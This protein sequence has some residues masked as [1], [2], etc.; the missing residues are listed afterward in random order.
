M[1]IYVDDMETPYIT[2]ATGRNLSN[3]EQHR[4]LYKLDEL[5]YG[6]HNVKVVITSGIFVMDGVMILAKEAPG[7]KNHV[8]ITESLEVPVALESADLA[9]ILPAT[10]KAEG[11][12]NGVKFTDRELPV[13][14]ND[15]TLKGKTWS[16]VTIDGI[17]IMGDIE[18]PITSRINLVIPPNMVYFVDAGTRETG[19]D[20]YDAIKALNIGLLNEVS[21]KAGDGDNTTASSTWGSAAGPNGLPKASGANRS[22]MFTSLLY[23]NLN[24]SGSDFYYDFTFDEPGIYYLAMGFYMPSGWG[25][26]T[27]RVTALGDA[28]AGP[29]T[30][31]NSLSVTTTPRTMSGMSIEVQQPGSVRLYFERRTGDAAVVSW[32][33]IHGQE[34]VGTPTASVES[35]TY[36]NAITV[37]LTSATEGADIYYTTDGSIPSVSDQVYTKLYTGPIDISSDTTLKA[38]AVKEG[39]KDSD[40][41]EYNYQI[42]L[43][44]AVTLTADPLVAPDTDF[45][46]VVKL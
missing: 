26:R 20:T 28:L 46:V 18:L 38:I 8:V 4:E 44:P 13:T 12:D 22:N 7:N 27:L 9:D 2:G 5:E 24:T 33:A 36:Y 21:D 10:V 1:D 23:A 34:P 19:S 43:S 45:T 29:K 39:M 25:S 35:G 32:I 40:V 3:S 16:S 37:E 11:Y 41:A 30:L 31:I 6:E 14:W 15:A 17:A 42:I